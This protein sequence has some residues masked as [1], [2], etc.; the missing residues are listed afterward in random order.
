MTP[1][2]RRGDLTAT[3]LLLAVGACSSGGSEWAVP[4]PAAGTTGAELHITGQV[5]HYEM[6]GGF[7]AIRGT[8]GVTYD[9][10]NLPR[11]FQQEGLSVEAD[12]RHRNDMVGIHQ[13][14]TIVEL[15]RIR[16]R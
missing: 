9:P 3:I 10:T 5:H 16:K 11:E 12:A 13:V 4:T 14:G 8:D 7:Y 6:E 15:V 1:L 2:L